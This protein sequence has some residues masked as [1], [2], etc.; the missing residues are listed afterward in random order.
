MLPFQYLWNECGSPLWTLHLR[1]LPGGVSRSPSPDPHDFLYSPSK[2]KSLFQF[3][4]ISYP[5]PMLET[6]RDNA[7][8]ELRKMVDNKEAF[9]VNDMET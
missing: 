5:I 9:N 1:D 2:K 6:G 3:K 8:T 4:E 7:L